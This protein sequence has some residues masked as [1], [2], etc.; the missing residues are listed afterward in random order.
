MRARYAPVIMSG[1]SS[2]SRVFSHSRCDSFKSARLLA[3]LYVCASSASSDDKRSLAQIVFSIL[4]AAFA[5]SKLAATAKRSASTSDS[6]REGQ[7]VDET[8]ALHG[9][10]ERRALGG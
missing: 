1:S 8:S 3:S 10:D 4:V 7:V 2:A 5:Q 6:E 9:Q